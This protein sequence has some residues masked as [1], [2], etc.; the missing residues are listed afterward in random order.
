MVD[1][2]SFN[3]EIVSTKKRKSLTVQI[4]PKKQ[5]E[6]FLKGRNLNEKIRI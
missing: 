6:F 2:N 4:G 5:V 1:I 3:Y